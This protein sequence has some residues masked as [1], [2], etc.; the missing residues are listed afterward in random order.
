MNTELIASELNRLSRMKLNGWNETD[1]REWFITPLLT[2]LGYQKD[3]DYDIN[4]EG[5]HLL[6]KRPFFFIGRDKIQLDYALLVRNRNFWIIEA[7]APDQE[8]L[9]EQAIFQAH[10]YSIHPEVN[11]R[12]F[13]VTNGLMTALYDTRA[14][15]NDFDPV[16]IIRQAA[17]PT[18]FIELNNRLGASR[19]RQMFRKQILDDIRHI[20]GTEVREE[21]LKEFRNQVAQ[22]IHELRPT[23]RE[24]SWE[25]YDQKK[26]DAFEQFRQL[27]ETKTLDQLVRIGLEYFEPPKLVQYVFDTRLSAVSAP[28][29]AEILG[30]ICKLLR[31]RLSTRH[32][33]NLVHLLLHLMGEHGDFVREN[34]ESLV[35]ECRRSIK[36][37]LSDYASNELDHALWQLEGNLYRVFYKLSFLPR[38][39][40][41]FEQIVKTRSGILQEEDLVFSPPTIAS[42]RLDFVQTSVDLAFQRARTADVWQLKALNQCLEELELAPLVSGKLRW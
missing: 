9:T 39:R 29:K 37:I 5:S 1:V 12:Y 8:D 41:V 15:G 20:L 11:A 16:L 17:L 38:P 24:N 32:R 23:V 7:K 10:F 21:A 35:E 40:D 31:G 28:M 4:R 33:A 19:I 42:E 2:L 13:M 30:S 36:L 34:A 3:T 26:A 27:I 14:L 22:V 25:V 6:P 18:K